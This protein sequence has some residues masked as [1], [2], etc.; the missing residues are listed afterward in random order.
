MNIF[1]IP[2]W[3][4]T[5]DKPHAGI[6]FK[7]Q[8][9][10]MAHTFP[11][12]NFAISTWGSHETDLL[13]YGEDHIFNIP[14]IF[15]FPFKRSDERK[16]KPNLTEYYSPALTWT[17][18]LLSG[19]IRGIVKVNERHFLSFQKKVG[20]IDVIHAHSAF[21]AGW[22]AMCLALKYKVPY[23]L[24]EHMGPFPFKSFLLK[25]GQL[26]QY[27]L[28]PFTY[29]YANIAVSPEQKSVLEGWDIHRVRYIP[30][31]INELFFTF[32]QKSYEES[33]LFTFFTLAR[34]EPGKGISFLLEAF[35]NLQDNNLACKLRIGGDG[36]QQKELQELTEE[37]GITE[38]V[39]WLGTLNRKEALKEYQ[40]CDTF[41][42]PSL[43]ENLPLV[44]LEAIACGK[45]II[46]TRCGGPESIINNT[47][48]ILVEPQYTEQLTSAM[49]HMYSNQERYDGM[50][51][52]NDALKKYSMQ[53]VCQ[54]IMEVYRLALQ[55]K[56]L[57]D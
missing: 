5:S 21:P 45:P 6:F 11:D 1:I 47:N 39:V 44:L 53:V 37:L 8:A 22:V 14:K 41:V 7:E 36:S 15:R 31:L 26:S 27:L 35:K 24:T 56:P 19:N 2:S 46:S 3:Y 16:L 29:S 30:N 42:L 52:R 40:S 34:L 28:K 51:I 33:R 50:M 10:A 55:D 25:N 32:Q 57:E 20:K 13:L 4:P 17:R 23:I 18:K 38:S 9:E 12:S 43:S 49:R 48:G 54:Q